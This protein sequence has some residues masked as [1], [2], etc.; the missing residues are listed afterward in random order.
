MRRTGKATRAGRE[1][2]YRQGRRDGYR[3]GYSESILRNIPLITEPVRNLHILYVTSGIGVPYPA[4]DQAIIDA[5]G[6]IVRA[7][8]VAMPSEDVVEIAASVKA[9]L[10][11]VLNGTALAA[12]KV[13]QLRLKGFKTAIWFTDDPYYTDWTGDIAL[14]YEYVFTLELNCVP[15]YQ[16]LGCQK[17]YYLPFAA[18]PHLFHPKRV[19]VSYQSDICFIGTAFWNRVEMIDRLAPLLAKK[20]VVIAGWWWDRLK[21]YSRLSSMIKLGDWMS[22]EETAS[23]YNGAKI[24]I[25]L[26]RSVDDSS[27]NNN[28]NKLPAVSVNPRT[29]EISGC[30]AF[31]LVDQRADLGNAY[32]PGVEVGTFS[33]HEELVDKIN[34]YLSH[35]EERQQVALNGMLKT[36]QAHTYY[37]RLFTMINHIFP[38][39]S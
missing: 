30:G 36:R 4:L 14:R 8:T 11:L 31:Q 17:V 21:N 38:H 25:N 15:F 29:F 35:E 23:Y 37:K 13:A 12:E 39:I 3:V 5:M 33:S 19:P 2:G 6:G 34:Y 18:N 7:V 27:I 20:K 26:H 22:P 16:N 10:V 32:L 28:A 9:D 24:V 1:A